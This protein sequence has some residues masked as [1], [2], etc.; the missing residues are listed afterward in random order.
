MLTY[1]ECDVEATW[2]GRRLACY[3]TQ[4][5][6]RHRARSR[7]LD[8]LTP[9]KEIARS[10]D[11]IRVEFVNR[12]RHAP[13]GKKGKHD[14]PI[15]HSQLFHPPASPAK[16]RAGPVSGLE[17]R[18]TFQFTNRFNRYVNDFVDR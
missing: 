8:S 11:A 7:R 15:R 13:R 16:R 1:A 12:G 5:Q 17:P 18:M 3:G 14:P 4:Q 10:S 2:R 9:Q 6:A